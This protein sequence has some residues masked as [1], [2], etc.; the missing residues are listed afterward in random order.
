MATPISSRSRAISSRMR[1]WV[2]TSSPVVGSSSTT[3]GGLADERDGDCHALLLAARELV[4]EAALERA[5]GRQVRR[6]RATAATRSSPAAPGRARAASRAIWSP[7][8]SDGLSAVPG[9]CG[10][11]ETSAPAQRA[12]ASRSSRPASSSPVDAHAAAGDPRA[13]PRVAEQ[14]QR[15]RRLAAARLADEA[16]DLARAARRSET[17]STIGRAPPRSSTRSSATLER[18]ARRSPPQR[19]ASRC[20]LPSVRAMRVADEV[21]GDRQQR[22]S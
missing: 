11:Y 5:V 13:R 10:T 19:L 3:S 16:E 21:H 7:I 2:T 6:A 14:R 8:R 17:S 1:A 20:D 15:G 12:A 9:S 18:P 4:R 22:R